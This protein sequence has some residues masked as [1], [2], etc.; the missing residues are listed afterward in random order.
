MPSFKVDCLLLTFLL[1]VYSVPPLLA[2]QDTKSKAEN[3]EI[4]EWL[5]GELSATVVRDD[6]LPTAPITEIEFPAADSAWVKNPQRGQ[7]SPEIFQRLSELSELEAISLQGTRF[8]NGDLVHL[9]SMESLRT[10]K[11]SSPLLDETGMQHLCAITGLQT[12]ELDYLSDGFD[13]RWLKHLGNLSS[14]QHFTLIGRTPNGPLREDRWRYELSRSLQKLNAG[15]KHRLAYYRAGISDND[16]Q[17]LAG[18]PLQ[19]LCLTRNPITDQGLKKLVAMFPDLR[20]LQ[21]NETDIRDSGIDDLAGLKKLEVLNLKRTPITLQEGPGLAQLK[22]LKS[23]DL[24][25]SLVSNH[26]VAQ[27]ANLTN[28]EEVNLTGTRINE[29][30]IEELE[31]LHSLKR[32]SLKGTPIRFH[33]LNRLAAANEH[34]DLSTLLVNRGLAK[35]NKRGEIAFLKLVNMDLRDADLD[36]LPRLPQLQALDLRNNHLT[37]DGMPWLVS[38]TELRQLKLNG[39]QINDMGIVQLI[40]LEKLSDLSVEQTDVTVSGL[41]NLFV[42]GQGRTAK[43]ALNTSGFSIKK[44]SRPGEWDVDLTRINASDDDLAVVSEMHNLLRFKLVGNEI[45]DAGIEQLAG[46]LSLKTLWIEE[47]GITGEALVHLAKIP[48]L[49]SLWCPSAAFRNKDLAPLA[50]MASLEVLNLCGCPIDDGALPYLEKLPNLR[51]LVIGV[52]QLNQ[53]TLQSLRAAR[54][55]LLVYE[56][57]RTALAMLRGRKRVLPR[58]QHGS[59]SL[60]QFSGIRSTVPD[61][62]SAE[63][64]ISEFGDEFFE[65]A[66]RCMLNDKT[67]RRLEKDFLCIRNLPT[68]TSVSI[69]DARLPDFTF[70]ALNELPK[71]RELTLYRTNFGSARLHELDRIAHFTLLGLTG[72]SIDEDQLMQLPEMPELKELRLGSLGTSLAQLDFLKGMPQL[73]KLNLSRTDIGD[74]DLAIVG[75]LTRLQNFTAYETGI[76]DAGLIHLAKLKQLEWLDLSTNKISDSGLEKLKGL[77][78]LKRVQVWNTEVNQNGNYPFKLK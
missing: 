8:Q 19:S 73:E 30:A 16:L 74:E 77:K 72:S 24:E 59:T 33:A 43:E 7:M 6:S 54:P 70:D 76:S 1:C 40:P 69:I 61:T 14:L 3:D 55:N 32:I 13:I 31:K 29:A 60:E 28:L 57:Q 37:N 18:L 22:S 58:I 56:S 64:L 48:S 17:L 45:T 35:L 15:Q 9:Q 46:H 66:T 34:I 41:R 52:G 26:G 25:G 78:N 36:F 4:A 65:V 11:L 62:E 51:S 38:L 47:A 63:L 49:T 50:D 75:S 12:L 42:F 5:S 27:L 44:I 10:L 71:L 20:Q 2:Q 68:I 53:A 23:I 21:V 67:F 39:N